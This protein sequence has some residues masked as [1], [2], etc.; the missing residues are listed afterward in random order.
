MLI[1]WDVLRQ[2]SVYEFF[3]GIERALHRVVAGMV[4]GTVIVVTTSVGYGTSFGGIAALLGML[5]SCSPGVCVVNIDNSFGAGYA[6][7]IIDRRSLGAN[8]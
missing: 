2:G 3:A 7:A 8:K 6:A 4:K 1:A 5:S